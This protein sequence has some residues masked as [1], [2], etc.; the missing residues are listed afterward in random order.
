MQSV[1]SAVRKVR[2]VVNHHQYS[3][4]LLLSRSSLD[5][6]AVSREPGLCWEGHVY[7]VCGEGWLSCVNML[8]GVARIDYVRFLLP[9]SRVLQKQSQ[10]MSRQGRV[11]SICDGLLLAV[12]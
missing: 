1:G 8:V 5:C 6:D 7:A 3:A 11:C 2:L 4:S 9:K 10:Y 12:S